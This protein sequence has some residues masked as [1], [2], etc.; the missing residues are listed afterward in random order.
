M[1]NQRKLT[2]Y[3]A[4]TISHP[5]ARVIRPP[6]RCTKC[7]SWKTKVQTSLTGKKQ[8][9]C[10]KCGHVMPAEYEYRPKDKEILGVGVV[11]EAQAREAKEMRQ[12]GIEHHKMRSER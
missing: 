6:P 11:T 2:T 4:T 9:W 10:E 1:T 8:Y 5:D 3:P 7:K 12:K